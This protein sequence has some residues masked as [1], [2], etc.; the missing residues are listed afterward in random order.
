M[1]GIHND[2]NTN[3]IFRENQVLKFQAE[4]L[5]EQGKEIQSFHVTKDMQDFIRN[6]DE[7]NFKSKA[8]EKEKQE[9]YEEKVFL[10]CCF[11]LTIGQTSQVERISKSQIKNGNENSCQ[12]C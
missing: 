8:L 10:I 3:T 11:D 2:F 1:N 12:G 7:K 5:V 6:G 4:E 9:E